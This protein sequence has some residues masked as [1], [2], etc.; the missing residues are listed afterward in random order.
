MFYL[1]YDI[2]FYY[3][4]IRYY[5]LMF[6]IDVPRCLNVKYFDH[7]PD[8]IGTK[9]LSDAIDFILVRSRTISHFHNDTNTL[10]MGLQARLS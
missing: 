9:F 6:S 8:M 5:R 3:N 4:I 10:P 7:S 2:T 1:I